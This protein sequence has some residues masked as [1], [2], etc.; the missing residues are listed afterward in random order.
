MGFNNSERKLPKPK[1]E[2]GE[3]IGN[4]RIL[5]YVG[6]HNDHGKHVRAEHVY[7]VECLNCGRKQFKRQN[8]M[9]KIGKRCQHCKIN[10]KPKPKAVRV[11]STD[12]EAAN[13]A[14]QCGW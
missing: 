3:V 9:R 2:A 4:F 13:I 8:S 5:S 11:W 12:D 7:E 10:N 6:H 14:R 1:H